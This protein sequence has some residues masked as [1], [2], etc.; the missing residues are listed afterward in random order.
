[1]PTWVSTK[2]RLHCMSFLGGWNTLLPARQQHRHR[3]R[4]GG[5]ARNLKGGLRFKGEERKHSAAPRRRDTA[6][7]REGLDHLEES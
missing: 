4:G 3:Q 6:A 7:L 1:M 2:T 5:W